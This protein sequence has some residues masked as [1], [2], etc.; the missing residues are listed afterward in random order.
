MKRPQHLQ[1]LIINFIA[2]AVEATFIIILLLSIPT[3]NHQ[4]DTRPVPFWRL[5]ISLYFHN[6][7]PHPLYVELL[8]L[9]LSAAVACNCSITLLLRL[10]MINNCVLLLCLIITQYCYH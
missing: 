2:A 9:R 10:M 3:V 8:L 6:P 4:T 5:K 7:P 1:P